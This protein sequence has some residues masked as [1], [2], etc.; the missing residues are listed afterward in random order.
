MGLAAVVAY[1]HHIFLNGEGYPR[2]AN[3]RACH[4][5]SRI[6]HVCDI[7]DAL[8]TNRPY[9]QAWAPEQTLAYLMEQSGRE[10]DPAVVD[11]FVAMISDVMVHRIPLAPDVAPAPAAGESTGSGVILPALAT[12]PTPVSPAPANRS[13]ATDQ[14][15]GKQPAQ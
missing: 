11:A 6:I 1:E 3:P 7:Y 10:L 2:P 5:A 15:A 9:R 13:A 14:T 12:E 8:C 4:F